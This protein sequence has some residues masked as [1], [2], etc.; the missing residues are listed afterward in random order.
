MPYRWPFKGKATTSKGLLKKNNGSA[1]HFVF[2]EESGRS[3]SEQA[4]LFSKYA[5]DS[6]QT[7]QLY[8]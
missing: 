4:L 1:G 5:S 2:D 3:V 8:S 6:H 7:I